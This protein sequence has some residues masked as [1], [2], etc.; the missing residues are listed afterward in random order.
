LKNQSCV[1]GKTYFEHMTLG[2]WVFYK[3][4]FLFY[5]LFFIHVAFIM[6]IFKKIKTLLN[7]L[8]HKKFN[9]IIY[10][11]LINIGV[12]KTSDFCLFLKYKLNKQPTNYIY[13]M[14]INKT[15]GT[16]LRESFTQ[17]NENSITKIIHLPHSVKL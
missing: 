6:I 8:S 9:E 12:S 17:I 2:F 11:F 7:L 4:F 3:I 16:S 10:L 14:H 1:V 13:F 15:G 5:F